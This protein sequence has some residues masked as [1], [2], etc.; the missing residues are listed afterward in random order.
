MTISPKLK[1]LLIVVVGILA[2]WFW[3]IG[4]EY[5]A[6]PSKGFHF[7]PVWAIVVR[8]IL[9][10]IT[11]TLTF[12]SM[13]KKINQNTGESWVPYLLAFQNGFF[14]QAALDAVT[15]QFTPA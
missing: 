12:M 11:A 7:G 1:L 14:W 6:D 13:Y 3:E 4:W 9:G 8:V 2:K 15:K 5:I 10:F